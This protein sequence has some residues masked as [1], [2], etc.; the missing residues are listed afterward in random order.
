MQG[1]IFIGKRNLERKTNVLKSIRPMQKGDEMKL[2]EAILKGCA[3]IVTK[4]CKGQFAKYKDGKLSE[5][6]TIGC[7]MYALGNADYNR[8][9]ESLEDKIA[10][11]VIKR[12]DNTDESRESIAAWLVEKGL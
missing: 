12:N 9:R 7:A 5:M 10:Y 6:C 11:E 1:S 2:S 3:K 8:L 4:K